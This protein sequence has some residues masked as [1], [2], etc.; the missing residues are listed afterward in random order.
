LHFNSPTARYLGTFTGKEE[1][2]H[3]VAD[4]VDIYKHDEAIL[5]RVAELAA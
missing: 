1:T 5:K 4:P 2:R 3:G